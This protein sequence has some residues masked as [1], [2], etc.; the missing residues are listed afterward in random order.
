MTTQSPASATTEFTNPNLEILFSE[1]TIRDK[2]AEMGAQIT[3]DYEGKDVVLVGVLKGSCVFLADL[4]RKVELPLS[5]D[6]MAIS[7]YKDGMQSSGDVEIL[8]I[9][10]AERMS[11]WSRTSSTPA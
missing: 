1:D 11:S 10:S 9:P 4:M 5:I 6:F 3:A 7:S 8:A 2:I